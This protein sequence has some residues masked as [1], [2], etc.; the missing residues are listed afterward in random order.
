MEYSELKRRLK[1]MRITS[2]NLGEILEI[3][4]TAVSRWGRREVPIYGKIIIELLE[5]LPIEERENYLKEK[6]S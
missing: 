6:L 5:R 3:S 2:T 4:P 1:K